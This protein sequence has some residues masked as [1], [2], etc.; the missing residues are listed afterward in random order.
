[1]PDDIGSALLLM[2]RNAIADQLGVAHPAESAMRPELAERGAVFVTLMKGGEL[3]GCI[4]SLEAWRPL[5]DDVVANARAAAFNDPRFSPLQAEELP[6]IRVEVSLLTP[7]RP[8]SFSSEA[9]AIGQL[10]PN[11]D[12][13]IL[14][15]AG[16][17]GTFLPQVW[18]SLAEP[19]QFMGQLKRKAGLPA[20]F[21]SQDI[22]LSRYAVDKWKEPT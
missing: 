19:R 16:H 8:M 15:Y 22:K 2:A 13:V 17:R 9:D 20:D 21:W 7:A 12:G 10:R 1:M 14:E 18:E 6:K 3:R 11:I 4:G 5:R